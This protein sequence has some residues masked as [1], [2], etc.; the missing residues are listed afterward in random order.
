MGA[1]M[2]RN[3]FYF[4]RCL[5]AINRE[6]IY[7]C[8]VSYHCEVSVFAWHMFSVIM[9]SDIFVYSE[10]KTIVVEKGHFTDLSCL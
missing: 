2:L 7:R 9:Q 4:C 3:R 1:E 6:V 5:V 10:A 8:K